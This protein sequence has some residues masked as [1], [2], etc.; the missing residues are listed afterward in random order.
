MRDSNAI[1]EH[2]KLWY[3]QLIEYIFKT[4]TFFLH[5]TFFVGVTL[6]AIARYSRNVPAELTVLMAIWSV[7]LLLH[8]LVTRRSES[9][10]ETIPHK[11]EDPIL[12]T[13]FFSTILNA[14]MWSM[15][16]LATD[17]RDSTPWHLTMWL[18]LAAVTVSTLIVGKRMLYAHWLKEFLHDNPTPFEEMKSKRGENLLEGIQLDDD[19]E[20]S[21]YLD[22]TSNRRLEKP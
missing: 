6:I 4:S 5:T 8:G 2:K 12:K 21:N 17:G 13:I 7:T 11:T 10:F 3:R 19:G 9:S 15:W 16:T 22:G 20:L 1:A 14:M 18:V